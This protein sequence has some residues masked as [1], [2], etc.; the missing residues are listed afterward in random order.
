MNKFT[1]VVF[2]LDG[3]LADSDLALV[4]VGL[5]IAKHFSPREGVSI[6][7]YLYLNGPP[8]SE[9]LAYLFP[10]DD[11]ELTKNKYYELAGTTI[12]DVSLFPGTKEVLQKLLEANVRLAIFT[13]RHRR[14]ME[15]ILKKHDLNQYFELIIAGND[16]FKPKPS[17]EAIKHIYETLCVPQEKTLYVGD[18][19]R[20]V[21]ASKEAGVEIAYIT[22]TRRPFDATLTVNYKLQNITEVLEVVLNGK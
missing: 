9:S 5:E 19:W 12:N 15:L 16:G 3:T 14:A 18:N 4:K 21:A 22:S 17:G 13:S 6:D 2:D 7:D 11:V 8:L 20:D 1:L 10:H